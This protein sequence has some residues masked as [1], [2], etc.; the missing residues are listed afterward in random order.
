V[1]R[2]LRSLAD[3]REGVL[4]GDRRAV[5]KAITL[6]ES[7]SPE[8]AELGQ[9]LLEALMPHSGGAIRLGVTGPPGVGKSSFIEVLGLELCRRGHRVAV[10]AVDPTSPLSGGSIL[11]DK[12]RMG[13][14]SQHE[15]AFIR[16]SPSGGTLGGVARRTRE[17]LVVCEAAGFDVVIVETVGVGQSEA[18]VAS[19]VDFFVLLLQPGAGDELQGIKKGVLELADVLVVHK[20]DGSNLEA[21]MRTRAEYAH[22]L[23]LLRPL[24]RVGGSTAA[25]ADEGD[26]SPRVLLASSR[27]REGIE[28]FW[29]GV[30]EQRRLRQKSGAIEARRSEQRRAWFWSLLEDELLAALHRDPRVAARLPDLAT[31]VES[32]TCSPPRAAREILSLFLSPSRP[33]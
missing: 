2:P 15:R 27:S 33:T 22:A 26:S 21:A 7:R 25:E 16:P 18:E 30:L 12:T 17:G 13:E 5:A 3:Y 14:L 23:E 4:A 1:S 29:E 9:Q 10:L 11:G 19:V 32:G 24:P 28:E 20:A 31:Q 8:H 6:L